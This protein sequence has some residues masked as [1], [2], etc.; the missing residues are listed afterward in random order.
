[1]AKKVKLGDITVDEFKNQ[2]LLGYTLEPLI[3]S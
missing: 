1:M 2:S 3:K